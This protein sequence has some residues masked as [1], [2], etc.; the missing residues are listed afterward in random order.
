MKKRLFSILLGV[1]LVLSLTGCGA[2]DSVANNKTNIELLEPVN[3]KAGTEVAALRNIYSGT[4]YLAYVQP[5]IK[6]YSF[7]EN[8]N[9]DRYGRFPGET[10]KKGDV[11]IYSDSESIDKQIEDMEESIENQE[12][13]HLEYLEQTEERLLQL[14]E[15]EYNYRTAVEA[16]D[17]ANFPKEIDDGNGVMVPNPEYQRGEYYRGQ[18]AI[19]KHDLDVKQI[20][21]AQKIQL[22]ELDHAYNLKQLQKLKEKS[23]DCKIVSDMNGYVV[24]ITNKNQGDGISKDVPVVAVGDITKKLVKC[25]YINKATAEKAKDM[26]AVVDGK[27]YEVEYQAM[28]TEEYNRLS[29]QGETIYTT[30]V[31]HDPDNEIASGDF[32]AIMLMNDSRE[33]TLSVY[34][35]AIHKDEAG[36]YVLVVKDG[37]NVRTSV[38]TGLS[39][40]VYTEI[41][42]GLQEGDVILSDNDH[43]AGEQ[44]KKLEKGSF[45]TK[46][47][48]KGSLGYPSS[49]SLKSGLSYGT[50]YFVEQLASNYQVVEKGDELMTIRVEPD[51]LQLNRQERSLQR[52]VERL[53]DMLEVD[54][55]KQNEDA[56]ES[57][58]ENIADIQEK[59]AEIKA[60]FATTTIRAD[61]DGVIVWMAEMEEDSLVHNWQTLYYIADEKTCYVEVDNANSLLNFGNEVSISYENHEGQVMSAPGMTANISQIG[62][63]SALQLEAALILVPSEYLT[64]MASSLWG[65]MDGWWNRNRFTVTATVR[66]MDNVV[67]VPRGAVWSKEGKTYVDVVREDGSV[68]ATSFV[69]GGFDASNYWVMEGLEEGMEICL[70]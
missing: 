12:T 40:G 5:Y 70:E 49:T 41:L 29:A 54:E 69:A 34:K 65:S 22:Y 59:I 19:A 20:E 2:T 68:V 60:D 36:R 47:E 10:V 23:K 17:R 45:S 63:S 35:D 9:F 7:S 52:A 24:S 14:M 38:E 58:R 37:Q 43:E 18:Y 53:N 50:A 61:R 27:R 46:Y 16:Y 28:E 30:F 57:A 51:T 44:R 25:E 42:E 55:D 64:D 8:V 11:L 66:Q 1:S 32:A 31:I 56:I 13:S 21:K 3:A 4:V 6:E 26:Y 48:E 15:N 39:D 62:L 33:N 67:L